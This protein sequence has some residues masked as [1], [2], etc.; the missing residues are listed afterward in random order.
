M[1]TPAWP[2]PRAVG[3]RFPPQGHQAC[4]LSAEIVL[5]LRYRVSCVSF[6]CFRFVVSGKLTGVAAIHVTN[7]QFTFEHLTHGQCLGYFRVHH[8][9]LLQ[10]QS[11]QSPENE[12]FQDL[13]PH[14]PPWTEVR[15]FI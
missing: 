8:L 11:P 9:L 7:W 4:L 14:D 10:F 6:L 13:F 3:G 1:Y 2:P 15:L 5:E 12:K